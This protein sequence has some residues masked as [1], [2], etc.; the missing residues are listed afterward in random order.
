[1]I[2]MDEQKFNEAS[3]ELKI[4]EAIEEI[5]LLDKEG[6]IKFKFG[7]FELSADE[8]KGIIKTWTQKENALMFQGSRFAILKNDEIQLAGKNIAQGRGNVVG[9]ITKDGDYLV[10]HTKDEG[11]IL[12][13]SVLINKIAWK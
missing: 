5:F 10:A 8:A 7:D 6:N 3:K 11:M 2:D 12:E 1:M 4:N 13:W 9:S